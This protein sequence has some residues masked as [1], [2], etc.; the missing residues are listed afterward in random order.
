MC[1][2]S[3]AGF[4]YLGS[5]SR[6]FVES[7]AL[8]STRMEI[9]MLEEVNAFYSEVVDRVD[10]T[11]VA[12]THEYMKRKHALPLPATFT[13]DAGQRISRAE[14]GMQVRLYSNY[15][16]RKDGGPRDDFE[17]R[18][19]EVLSDRAQNKSKDLAYHEFIDRD[20][21]PFL[22]Y[23]KGQL[24]QRSCLNCH[25]DKSSPK[26][27]WHEGDLAGVL[28]ITRSLDRDIA[29]TDSGLRGAFLVMGTVA[30]FGAGIGLAFVI[31]SRLKSTA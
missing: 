26:R 29:R 22:R 24:M 15:P 11:K 12:V 27:G 3:A 7:T 18:S 1:L 2:G 9:S 21:R 25:N 14:S 20:G 28:V 13:I 8:D 10:A 17:R 6:Y 19:L 23:A 16:W 30:V 4:W 31:R 5:L